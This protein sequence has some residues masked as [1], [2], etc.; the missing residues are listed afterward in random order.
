MLCLVMLK[1]F[2]NSHRAPLNMYFIDG[3]CGNILIT[4]QDKVITQYTLKRIKCAG[5]Y[6]AKSIGSKAIKQ[7]EVDSL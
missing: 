7:S 5:Q 6:K 1:A 3:R 2:M 4:A